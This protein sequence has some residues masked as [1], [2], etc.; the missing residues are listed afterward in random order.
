MLAWMSAAAVYLTD[1]NLLE[2][3]TTLPDGRVGRGA[4]AAGWKFHETGEAGFMPWLHQ[5][6]SPHSS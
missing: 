3:V 4:G 2:Y 5:V 6:V 1:G